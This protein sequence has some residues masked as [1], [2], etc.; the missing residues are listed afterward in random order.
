[1]IGRHYRP[2][3][4][5]Y[6]RVENW[7][8]LQT[9]IATIHTMA[10]IDSICYQPADIVSI[11]IGI[12]HNLANYASLPASKSL[13]AKGRTVCYNDSVILPS[14][15]NVHCIGTLSLGSGTVHNVPNPTS[16]FDFREKFDA[17]EKEV[18]I[19]IH[20]QY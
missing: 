19:L 1:V 20:I 12:Q 13:V 8:T 5:G 16:K 4:G 11:F 2:D 15:Q 3:N 14:I 6:Q 17:M 10:M 18:N 7:M 9:A